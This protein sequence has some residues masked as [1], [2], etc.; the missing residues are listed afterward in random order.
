M[1]ACILWNVFRTVIVD[2]RRV[3]VTSSHALRVFILKLYAK[4]LGICRSPKIYN[5]LYNITQSTTPRT[6]SSLIFYFIISNI[7]VNV[8]FVCFSELYRSYGFELQSVSV[9]VVLLA[10]E[11]LQNIIIGQYAITGINHVDMLICLLLFPCPN[12]FPNIIWCLFPSGM[13]WLL[14]LF[15]VQDWCGN[16]KLKL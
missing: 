4:E 16:S 6:P 7:I 15:K 12:V 8:P 11:C 1:N 13:G 10:F 14:F 5:T 3:R 9:R 2:R